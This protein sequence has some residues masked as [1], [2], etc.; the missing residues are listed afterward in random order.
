MA[1]FYKANQSYNTSTTANYTVGDT[2]I[3]VTTIPDNVP[4]IITLARGTTKETR[5]TVT[6]TG[7][8]QLTGV[9]RLDGANDNILSGSSVECMNDE[10]FVNQLETAV[11]TQA[12]LTN[13]VYDADS[14]STDAYE[15]TLPVAPTT[16]ADITGLPITFKANMANTGACTLKVNTL[17]LK[18]IKKNYNADLETGDIVANQ[19]VT[20]AYDGTNFQMLSHIPTAS[21]SETLTNKTI[22][23]ESNTVTTI[24]SSIYCSAN[25]TSHA[26]DAVITWDSENWDVGGFHD[27]GSNTSRLTVPSAGKYL[28]N[29]NIQFGSTEDKYFW[30]KKNGSN[31]LLGSRNSGTNHVGSFLVNASANDYFEV[32]PG[33]AGGTTFTVIG[34]VTAST[35]SIIK[36]SD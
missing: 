25:L 13:I 29:V 21:T 18:T 3:S 16:L 28:I 8:G 24:S 5:F 14:G 30:L 26:S 17:T 4:T 10:E 19:L 36:L 34:G 27:T 33:V 9:A 6:G 15:I 31:F 1:I 12:N 11:F 7:V 20:V 32:A 2:T 23:I 35:F 22:D